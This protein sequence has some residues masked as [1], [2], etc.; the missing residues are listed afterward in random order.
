MKRKNSLVFF[1]LFL[2]FSDHAIAQDEQEDPSRE[3][4]L[5]VFIDC[6]FCDLD[7]IRKNIAY[8]NYVR[9]RK[10]AQ[11]HIITTTQRTGSGAIQ[12]TFNFIGQLDFQDQGSELSAIAKVDATSDE[13]R[14]LRVKYLKIGLMP[15]VAQTPMVDLIEIEYANDGDSTDAEEVIDKWNNWVFRL[16]GNAWFN[17][18]AIFS[19]RSI[20]SSLSVNKI[21]DKWKFENW[22]SFNYNEN[23]YELDSATT[24]FNNNRGFFFESSVV[25][26]INDHWSAGIVGVVRQ[27]TFQN[28]DY[29]HRISPAIEYNIFDYKDFNEKQIRIQ[30]RLG[31]NTFQYVDTTIYNE[32]HENLFNHNLSIAAEFIQKWGSFEMAT[33]ASQYFHDTSLRRLDI[34]GAVN[35][36]IVTGLSVNLRGN[37]EFIQDQIALPKGG[38]S[39]IDILTQQQQLATNY[40][41]WGSIGFTYTFGSIYNNIVNPRFGN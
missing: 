4:A 9:D 6:N 35:W 5:T 12:Y 28:I 31:Y 27:S 34:W 17:G 22:A 13:R 2:L 14:E 29:N 16:R 38:A 15:Y 36:R 18:Q 20:N 1:L 21:T 39:D 11:I 23:T 25:R 41:Y 26:S 33:T 10:L 40:A 37:I 30:Y 7:Y 19:S 3:D 32:I 8:V 24:I